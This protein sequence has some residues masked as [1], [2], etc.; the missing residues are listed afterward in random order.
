MHYTVGLRLK[1]FHRPLGADKVSLAGE[2]FGACDGG[3][4]GEGR[5]EVINRGDGFCT[6]DGSLAVGGGIFGGDF[7]QG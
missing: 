4:R 2:R 6:V 3:G 1:R 5:G 7:E